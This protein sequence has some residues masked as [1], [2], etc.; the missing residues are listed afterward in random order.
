[1][2]K[3][4]ETDKEAIFHTGGVFHPVATLADESGGRLQIALDD[5]CY[6]LCLRQ[7]GAYDGTTPAEGEEH[8][9]GDCH[10][11]WATHIFPEAFEVLRTLP[12]PR[13]GGRNRDGC[14][15]HDVP[16]P[17]CEACLEWVAKRQTSETVSAEEARNRLLGSDIDTGE[18][19]RLPPEPDETGEI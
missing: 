14:Q 7:D 3:Q 15:E 11:I 10:Y 1:M 9:K 6:V 12:P 4:I 19:T 8:V 5:G 2:Y 17:G 18:I 13:K 16:E